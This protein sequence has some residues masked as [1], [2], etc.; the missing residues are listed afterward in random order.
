MAGK[1]LGLRRL[2]A[3]TLVEM[4]AVIAIIGVLGTMI[5]MALSGS[6]SSAATLGNAQRM[7]SGMFQAA[8]THAVMKGKETAVIFYKDSDDSSKYLRFVGIVYNDSETGEDWKALNRGSYL[9]KGIYFIPP[10]SSGAESSDNAEKT[11]SASFPVDVADEEEW[12]GYV[13]NKNG[14]L[15]TSTYL[16]FAPLDVPLT[17]T[18]AESGAKP[19][20]VPEVTM[21]IAV[22][23]TGGIMMLDYLGDGVYSTLRSGIDAVE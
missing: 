12:Y 14:N 1:R 22:R 20:V 8:R 11:I 13:F 2:A 9:P 7:V 4:L 21:G 15:A 23:K 10:G 19:N 17:A 6:G 5:G 3:F 18:Q 16:L